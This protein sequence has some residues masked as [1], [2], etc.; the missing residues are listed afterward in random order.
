LAAPGLVVN[1]HEVEIQRRDAK[2]MLGASKKIAYDLLR[3]TRTQADAKKPKPE[4]KNMKIYVTL[5]DRVGLQF[6]KHWN[7]TRRELLSGKTSDSIPLLCLLCQMSDADFANQIYGLRSTD[8]DA[9]VHV[10]VP[11]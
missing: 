2:R 3:S 10:R 4:K 1:V 7:A 11:F 8:T 5:D 6:L 9:I